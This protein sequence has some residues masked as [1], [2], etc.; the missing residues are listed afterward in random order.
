MNSLFNFAEIRQQQLNIEAQHD[1]DIFERCINECPLILCK[2]YLARRM[3]NRSQFNEVSKASIFSKYGVIEQHLEDITAH[4][5]F[6]QQNITA[7]NNPCDF[8]AEV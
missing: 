1:L 6:I 3:K 5:N 7:G 2:Y 4:N 8:L